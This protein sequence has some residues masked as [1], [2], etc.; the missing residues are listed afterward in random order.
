M[1]KSNE[2]RP[3]VCFFMLVTNRDAFLATH[4]IK[5][6]EKLKSCFDFNWK[7]VVYM[8]CLKDELK[9]CATKWWGK[10]DYVELVDNVDIVDIEQLVPG[11]TIQDDNGGEHYIEGKYEPGCV[12]WTREFHKSESDYWV[13]VD[14]D[15]EILSPCFVLEM[16]DMLE[17]DSNLIAV[18][19]DWSGAK[20]K[21]DSYSNTAIVAMSR[22]HTWFC[23]YK[24]KAQQCK[25][26][27]FYYK[28]KKYDLTLAFDDTARFQ[29]ALKE[30]LGYELKSVD[31]QKYKNQFIHYGAFS[32]NNSLD[33]EKKVNRYRLITILQHRG[34]FANNSIIDKAIRKLFRIIHKKIYK[35]TIKERSHYNYH[36]KL[37][38]YK[39]SPNNSIK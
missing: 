29:H 13:M 31:Y 39:V 8:N 12:V 10:F 16:F 9:K 19:S 4:A 15:F 14:A 36:S 34:L 26:S 11:N 28:E 33:T 23:A 38:S 6:F 37:D 32:K 35:N 3:T 17:S 30:Q 20:S 25:I 22:Y 27:F 1:V 7:L 5:S 18:S 24:R 21:I 2:Q